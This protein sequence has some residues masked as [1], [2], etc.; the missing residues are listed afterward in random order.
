MSQCWEV[1]EDGERCESWHGSLF[2]CADSTSFSVALVI[3]AARDTDVPTVY[4]A[5]WFLYDIKGW[6]KGRREPTFF[7]LLFF[8]FKYIKKFGFIDTFLATVTSYTEL[9]SDWSKCCFC[10]QHTP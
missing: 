4:H 1:L 6:V 2:T 3:P 8:F 7:F 9:R 10:S 5:K